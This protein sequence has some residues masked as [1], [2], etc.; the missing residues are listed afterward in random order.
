MFHSHITQLAILL[1]YIFQFSNYL[2]E[3]EKTNVFELKINMIVLGPN[4][5]LRI[6]FLST[7]SLPFSLY[8]RDHVSQPYNTN[9]NIIFLYI[10]ILKFFER[11][12]EDTWHLLT[13]CKSQNKNNVLKVQSKKEKEKNTIGLAWNRWNS[14]GRVK[15]RGRGLILWG[16]AINPDEETQGRLYCADWN[17]SAQTQL[18][19]TGAYL[20]PYL[21]CQISIQPLCILQVYK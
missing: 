2:R 5:R 3:V 8:V 7:V 9:Y 16:A 15:L 14:T 11:S 4:I 1:F 13:T 12:R 19:K 18:Q 21:F 20:S 6:L 10:L 17:L